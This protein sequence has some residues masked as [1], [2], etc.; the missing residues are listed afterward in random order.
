MPLDLLARD[1]Q[2]RVEAVLVSAEE[3]GIPAEGKKVPWSTT[4]HGDKHTSYRCGG[5][6]AASKG[7]LHSATLLGPPWG[8]YYPG[9]LPG[10]QAKA[11]RQD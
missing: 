10:Q 8:R 4:G 11:C 5:C 2:G 3:D 1:H 9:N 7:C 6:K